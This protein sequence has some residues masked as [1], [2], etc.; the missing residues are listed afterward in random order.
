VTTLPEERTRTRHWEGKGVDLT[1]VVDQLTR[2]HGELAHEDTGDEEHPHPRNSVM[3]LV[4]AVH[5]EEREDAA[6]HVLESI[7]AGH[8]LR[9]I[10][11]HRSAEKGDRLDA[12]ILTE[13]H[14]LL[15]GAP[16]QREQITLRVRGGALQHISSLLEPLLAPDVPTY[17]W[18]T[19]T[20]PLEDPGLRDSLSVCDVLIVDSE[21]FDNRVDAFLDLAGLAD[22]LG[23]RISFVD[24]H[25][26]RQR[27]WRETVAQFFAP[28]ERRPY[29]HHLQRLTLDCVGRGQASR[30]GGALVAGWIIGALGWKLTQA[31]RV[32]T[33]T[34]DALLKTP[35]GHMVQLTFRSVASPLMKEGALR[36][37]RLEGRSGETSIAMKVEL[38]V[39]RPDHAH[40]QVDMGGVETLH[41]RLPLPEPEEAELLL[42]ALSAARRDRVYVR[43]LEAAAS[44]VDGLR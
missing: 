16:V 10:V 33:S 26:A 44:L 9:A 22:R 23:G 36:A 43:S 14:Q 29:L 34:A 37:V 8:P 39:E 7:A 35:D 20:P 38:N 42:Q 25:W 19:G 5:N 40:V 21:N 13:A 30:I 2:L 1:T 28:A 3:N 6:H 11:L 12:E 17:L 41:Q 4:I 32:S 18:W 31:A 24:L 27:A 15:N